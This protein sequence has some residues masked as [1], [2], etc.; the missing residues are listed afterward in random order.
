[1]KGNCNQISLVRADVGVGLFVFKVRYYRNYA[2]LFLAMESVATLWQGTV[3]F[4]CFFPL[5]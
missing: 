4:K 1:M 3:T 2:E 5:L